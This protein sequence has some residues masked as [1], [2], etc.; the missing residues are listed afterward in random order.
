MG[1]DDDGSVKAVDVAVGV[2]VLVRIVGECWRVVS[3][4]SEDP[5]EVGL[6]VALGGLEVVEKVGID[7]S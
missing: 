2:D 1:D 4:C 3:S 5:D 7:W 6:S